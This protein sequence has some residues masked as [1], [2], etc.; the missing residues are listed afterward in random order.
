MGQ[1]SNGLLGRV[2]AIGLR[3]DAGV[4]GDADAD[5]DADA[6]ALV[7]GMGETGAGWAFAARGGGG[8]PVAL[9]LAAGRLDGAAALGGAFSS[10]A[11]SATVTRYQSMDASGWYVTSTS[12]PLRLVAM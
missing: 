7:A 6:E 5:A 1:G 2:G 8:V 12:R 9:G 3:A 11:T 4:D 10:L